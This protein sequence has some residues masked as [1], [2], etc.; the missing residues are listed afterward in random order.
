MLEE[1]GSMETVNE[2]VE[3]IKENSVESSIKR[4]ERQNEPK[5]YY[6]VPM[7]TLAKLAKPHAKNNDLAKALWDTGILDAQIVAVH[8]ADP[9][10]IDQDTLWLWCDP[11][12]SLLVL[13]KL[14]GHVLSVRK[15]TKEFEERL[16]QEDNPVLQRIVWALTVRQVVKQDLNDD[17]VK[18]LF[19][20]IKETLPTAEEPLKW[21]VNHCL[22]EIGVYYDD[23]TDQCIAF[24]EANGAYREMKV[25]KSC[26]SPFA[27]EWIHVARY[28]RAQ[29]TK[30]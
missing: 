24:G 11:N 9:K 6:G 23:W 14:V 17:E 12:V 2:I 16:L 28:N 25:S 22:C 21:T 20:K 19:H 26:T 30:K 29:R 7:G 5:P 27:P 3:F 10:T 18:S 15:D 13:D 8:V 4:Y 1:R